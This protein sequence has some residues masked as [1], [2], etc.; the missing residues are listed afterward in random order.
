MNMIGISRLMML[1]ELQRNGDEKW[2]REHG[3]CMG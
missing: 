1:A 2:K 3:A